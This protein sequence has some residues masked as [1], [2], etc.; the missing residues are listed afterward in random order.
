MLERSWQITQTDCGQETTAECR[1][2]VLSG[3]GSPAVTRVCL[4][5]CPPQV[6]TGIV[7]TK[8]ETFCPASRTCSCVVSHAHG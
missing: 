5:E 4:S 1:H 6:A 3:I 8:V 2:L 7:L